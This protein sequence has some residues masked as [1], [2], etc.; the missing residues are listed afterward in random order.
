[1]SSMMNMKTSTIK[2]HLISK[3]III[4]HYIII[5]AFYQIQVIRCNSRDKMS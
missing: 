5:F 1:M 2:P 3:T 4:Q